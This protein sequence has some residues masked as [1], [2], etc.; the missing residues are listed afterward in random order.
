MDELLHNGFTK[1]M[2]ETN[3][4]ETLTLSDCEERGGDDH[5]IRECAS[6]DSRSRSL[7]EDSHR[8]RSRGNGRDTD[9][10]I[11]RGVCVTQPKKKDSLSVEGRKSLD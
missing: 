4:S 8:Q 2:M 6:A 7:I 1:K 10:C 5:K 3:Q 9:Q 11:T